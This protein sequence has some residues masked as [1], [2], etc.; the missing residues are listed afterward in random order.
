V[1]TWAVGDV[2]GCLQPLRE[3]LK[4]V[5]FN[6]DR[7]LLWSVGDIVNRGPSCLETLRFFHDRRDNVQMV[8]GNHDLHLLAAASGARSLSRSDTLGP[9]LGARDS[10]R[11]LE[12]LRGRPLLHREYGA[13]LVHAGIPPQWTSAEAAARAAE[14]ETALRGGDCGRFLDK[15]ATSRGAGP[16]T[17]PATRACA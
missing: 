17:S 12:W 5:H 9:I 14:V 1:A 3:L 7:D 11:L 8:L 2:Q 16:T 15:T 6:D 4:R 13:T 10:D